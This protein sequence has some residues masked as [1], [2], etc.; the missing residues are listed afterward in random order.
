MAK[1]L[2]LAH[3]GFGKTFALRT[4]P[5]EQ[6]FLINSDR[7]ELTGIKN[8]RTVYKLTRNESGSIDWDST[9]LVETRDLHSIIKVVRQVEKLERIKYVA[10][11]TI[12]H[13]LTHYYLTEAIGKGWDNYL[14]LGKSFYELLDLITSSEKNYIING[15]IEK[16]VSSTGAVVL[17]IKTPG[18]MIH[19]MV[20]V[21]YFSTVLVGEVKDGERYYRAHSRGIDD[22]A[23]CPS[24]TDENGNIIS[25][26][27]KKEELD[28]FKIIT[29]LNMFESGETR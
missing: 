4:L 23:K 15:H 1:V 14:E 26:L 18:K 24:T 5:P 10:L 12:T 19:D 7:K 27:D 25:S 17:D 22:P 20:P 9:N 11:D 29:K 2:C 21:S 3:S 8:W 6:T 28:M 16:V 13:A